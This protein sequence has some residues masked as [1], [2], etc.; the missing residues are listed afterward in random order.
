[1]FGDDITLTTHSYADGTHIR[2]GCH[3][4][5]HPISHVS[6]SNTV[7]VCCVQLKS[8]N[9]LFARYRPGG[10]GA[11]KNWAK[12]MGK[13]QINKLRLQILH[14]ARCSA[15]LARLFRQRFTPFFFSYQFLS[16]S[17]T[18]SLSLSLHQFPSFP[19]PHCLTLG[20]FF[21]HLPPLA[22][23]H[24]Y[25]QPSE[26]RRF[27]QP[28]CCS[29][30]FIVALSKL[31]RFRHHPLH[32]CHRLTSPTDSEKFNMKMGFYFRCFMAC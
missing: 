1:M 25:S 8:V 16:L 11:P 5:C 12:V 31:S 28:L 29:V 13:L 6:L 14:L 27:L 20:H 7:S 9:G 18:L 32:A 4:P 2:T 26:I 15:L 23:P 19:I 21:V 30:R 10:G 17:L 24:I 22:L 3:T